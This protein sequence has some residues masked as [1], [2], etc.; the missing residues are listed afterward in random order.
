MVGAYEKE[1]AD[2]LFLGWVI[3][4]DPELADQPQSPKEE[5]V[6]GKDGLIS[7]SPVSCPKC[8][9]SGLLSNL[10]EA[11]GDGEWHGRQEAGEQGQMWKQWRSMGGRYLLLPRDLHGSLLCSFR[12]CSKVASLDKPSLTHTWA[13]EAK[14]DNNE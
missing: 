1:E 12:S 6:L 11:A 13:G 7:Q 2:T 5:E 3:C 10:T 4:S 9:E 8:S 14:L